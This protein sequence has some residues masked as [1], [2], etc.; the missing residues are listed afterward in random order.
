MG[1]GEEQPDDLQTLGR[2]EASRRLVGKDQVGAIGDGAR[3][4]NALLFSLAHGTRKPTREV[5]D[6]QQCEDLRSSPEG[7]PGRRA[8][9][10]QR[11]GHVLRRRESL[12]QVECLEYE[13]DFP[14]SEML[15]FPCFEPGERLPAECHGS[16]GRRKDPRHQR[17][18][19]RLPAAAG[20]EE[21]EQFAASC[22]QVNV[23]HS[24]RLM[25]VFPE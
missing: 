5:I 13:T 24:C 3:N 19:S 22:L 18:Q 21:Q 23:Q 25:R 4:R 16:A 10:P 6:M 11:N 15:Q 7:V 1:I 2:F 20:T 8:R 12:D 9:K 17:Q 14:R